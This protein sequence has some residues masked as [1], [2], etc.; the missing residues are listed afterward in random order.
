MQLGSSSH[1]ATITRHVLD[2]R[3]DCTVRFAPRSLHNALEHRSDTVPVLFTCDAGRRTSS[4]A[5]QTLVLR[6]LHPF[7]KQATEISLYAPN[8]SFS[9]KRRLHLKQ[10]VLS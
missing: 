6:T 3:L 4:S 8:T 2:C 9:S 10:S 7:E 5:V 1:S